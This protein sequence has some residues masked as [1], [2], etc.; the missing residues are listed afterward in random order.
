MPTHHTSFNPF[1][2]AEFRAISLRGLVQGQTV[3]E[4]KRCGVWALFFIK[5]VGTDDAR[6]PCCWPPYHR[7]DHH[8]LADSIADDHD[9]DHVE[10][11]DNVE[12]DGKNAGKDAVDDENDEDEK[13]D[14]ED[15]TMKTTTTRRRRSR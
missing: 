14:E 1:F 10:Q 11:H 7:A 8:V 2:L 5:P 9:R 6:S 13:N 12:D 15:N 3:D 4:Q